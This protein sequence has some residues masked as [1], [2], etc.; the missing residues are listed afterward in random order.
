MDRHPFATLSAIALRADNL[1]ALAT[2]AHIPPEHVR[3]DAA[4]IK[5]LCDQ[6]RRQMVGQA[7]Q[8][9]NAQ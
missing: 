1:L 3:A 6:A 5:D 4:R 2:Q 7:Q 8:M 9:E